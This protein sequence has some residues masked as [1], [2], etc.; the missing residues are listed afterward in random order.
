MCAHSSP[1]LKHGT[2]LGRV[3]RAQSQGLSVSL[4]V[5]IFHCQSGSGTE[6]RGLGVLHVPWAFS[7]RSLAEAWGGAGGL[8]AAMAAPACVS[9]CA[10]SCMLTLSHVPAQ[11]CLLT[12]MCISLVLFFHMHFVHLLFCPPCRYCNLSLFLLLLPGLLCC[13]FL[14]HV[15]LYSF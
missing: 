1:S 11:S 6:W 15:P 7:G 2:A 14:H 8:R 13:L 4:G 9:A 5:R 3:G 12:C 10:L